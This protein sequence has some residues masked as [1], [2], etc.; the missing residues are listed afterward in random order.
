MKFRSIYIF[1]LFFLRFK[2]TYKTQE[3]E[4]VN[5]PQELNYYKRASWAVLSDKY[6][7]DF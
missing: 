6:T 5:A 2:T 3:F 7:K 4:T 1:F